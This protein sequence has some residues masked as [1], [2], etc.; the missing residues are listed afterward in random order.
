M[1]CLQA[2][3]QLPYA[4]LCPAEVRQ[5]LDD[6]CAGGH[7]RIAPPWLEVRPVSSPVPSLS[8]LEL[9]SG[10]AA[11]IH[12]ALELRPAAVAIDE[13]KGRRAALAVGL[14]VT[15]SLGLVA[16]A[17][18]RGV[19]PAVRPLIERAA[20]AGIRYHP[21]VVRRVLREIGEL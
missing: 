14:R 4:F 3:G 20:A 21:E 1:D 2:I 9:D 18:Q 19:V 5:E 11:V 17:C 10:E 13:S 7:P 6:G 16:K 8:I 15:G 12:L